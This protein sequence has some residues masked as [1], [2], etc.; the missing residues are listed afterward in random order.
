MTSAGIEVIRHSFGRGTGE[1]PWGTAVSRRFWRQLAGF[2]LT[3]LV[4]SSV[5]LAFGLVAGRVFR[6]SGP[7]VQS[8][9][10]RTTLLAVVICPFASAA[11]GA[12]GFDGFSLALPAQTNKPFPAER[13]RAPS[14]YPSGHSQ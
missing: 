6:R 12:A 9:V 10:Y 11:L 4:Q 7:A 13:L 14:R 8:G 2:G 1:Q 3:W 5:L